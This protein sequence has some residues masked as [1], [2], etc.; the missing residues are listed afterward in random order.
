[1]KVNNENIER[2][3]NFFFK[4]MKKL[5]GNKYGKKDN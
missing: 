4:P 1:M 5:K 2:K 3:I